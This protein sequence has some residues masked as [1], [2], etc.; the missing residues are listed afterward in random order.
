ML[1]CSRSGLQHVPP[2]V[3]PAEGERGSQDSL[4]TKHFRDSLIDQFIMQYL[5]S[6]NV[7]HRRNSYLSN[8]SHSARLKTKPPV[9]PDIQPALRC[10]P[11]SSFHGLQ[12]LMCQQ[13]LMS[14]RLLAVYSHDICYTT[15]AELYYIYSI[16]ERPEFYIDILAFQISTWTLQIRPS[17]TLPLLRLY[18]IENA[19]SDIAAD[20]GSTNS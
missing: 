16:R 7:K 11:P 9:G 19:K 17:C 14:C 3:A 20:D 13:I 5:T 18:M 1:T 6:K 15:H 10:A 8:T 12:I 2:G 4:W